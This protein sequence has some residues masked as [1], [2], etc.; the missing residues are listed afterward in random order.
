MLAFSLVITSVHDE[1]FGCVISDMKQH[2]RVHQATTL[3]WQ[4]SHLDKTGHVRITWHRNAFVQPLLWWKSSITY[5]ER[6]FVALGIPY[7]MRMRIVMLSSVVCTVL[8][9]FFFI[10]SHKRLRFRGEGGRYWTQNVCFDFLYNFCLK[11]FTFCEKFSE[12]LSY[13]YIFLHVKYS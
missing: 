7:A 9:Y 6:V 1:S 3:Q 10:L 2:T 8:Q 11:H 12:V 5:S 4:L 13:V